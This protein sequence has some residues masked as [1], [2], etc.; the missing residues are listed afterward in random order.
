MEKRPFPSWLIWGPLLATAPPP[1]TDLLQSGA[2]SK[3]LLSEKR[4]VS[5]DTNIFAFTLD[6]ASQ[7]IGL[8]TGQHVMMQ[9]RDPVTREVIIRAYM[10][11][12][13]T[14]DAGELNVLVNG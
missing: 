3:A 1:R 4:E 6:Y 5:S 11:I 14:T 7:T 10:P 8:P 12:S 13:E 2:W 9:L